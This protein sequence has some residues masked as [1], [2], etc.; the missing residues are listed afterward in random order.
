MISGEGFQEVFG[1]VPMVQLLLLLWYHQIQIPSR[2]QK[3]NHG[4]FSSTDKQ[5]G[6]EKIKI[7][8]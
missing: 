8:G 1:E 7:G 5:L 6:S 2:K 4:N 3:H